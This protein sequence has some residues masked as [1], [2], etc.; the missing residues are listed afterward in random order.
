MNHESSC[1]E[2]CLAGCP[3]VQPEL[4]CQSVPPVPR[5][6]KPLMSTTSNE[7]VP[8]HVL[9]EEFLQ[10]VGAENSWRQQV[11]DLADKLCGEKRPSWPTLMSGQPVSTRTI[12]AK[13]HKNSWRAGQKRSLLP[14]GKIST[15]C[16][17]SS[18]RKKQARKSNEATQQE[19]FQKLVRTK[20]V[21]AWEWEGLQPLVCSVS[22]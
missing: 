1:P 17:R 15:Q 10:K 16:I 5:S 19:W 21:H 14:L 8:S 18:C 13:K 7:M 6:C 20:P 11:N 4:C 9:E 2:V 3:G 22:T 12:A